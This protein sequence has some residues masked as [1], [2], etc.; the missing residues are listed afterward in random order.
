[1]LSTA[2]L[3]TVRVPKELLQVKGAA[4]EVH[5]VNML[6]TRSST[7]GSRILGLLAHFCRPSIA[8]GI[9]AQQTH[10]VYQMFRTALGTACSASQSGRAGEHCAGDIRYVA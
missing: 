6:A 7:D 8:A 10:A 4:L 2:S 5:T 3:G 1:M 9:R